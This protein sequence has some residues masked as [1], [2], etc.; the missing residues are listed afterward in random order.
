MTQGVTLF[1]IGNEILA[2]RRQDVHFANTLAACQA[3]SI[4]INGVHFLRDDADTL[5]TAFQQ[6]IA[7]NQTVLSFGGIGATPDDK[8]R[9]TVAEAMGVPLAYHPQG[10]LL[11]EEKFGKDFNDMRRNLVL[12]PEGATLIPNP[13]NNVPG[14]S[15]GQIYCVPGFPQ[16]AKPMIEWVLDEYGA[17]MKQPLIYRSI[18]AFLAES[19]AIALLEKLEGD[20]PD[21]SVSCLPQMHHELELGF[22]GNEAR[23]DEA[24]TVSKKWLEQYGFKYF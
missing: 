5:L 12:F 10:T 9:A 11:L 7:T 8:T 4:R 22:E 23:C 18:Q 16:M 17:T 15:I 24:I 13:V 6:A 1:I 14:F 3:R 19:Q 2:G 21:V 20:F